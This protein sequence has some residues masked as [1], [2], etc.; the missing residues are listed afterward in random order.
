[1][2]TPPS[3]PRRYADV[4]ARRPSPSLIDQRAEV[5]PS[6]SS[7]TS[8]R[9][10]I[11]SPDR[12]N[13]VSVTLAAAEQRRL[14]PNINTL[15]LRSDRLGTLVRSLSRK[16]SSSR[17]WESFVTGHRGR[18][19]LSSGLEGID[20]PAIPL[21]RRW[22]DHGVPV[23]TSDLPWSTE[24][25]DLCIRRG[26]HQSAVQHNQF[27]RE[28]MAEFIENGFWTV[29][30]YRQVRSLPSLMLS[31]AAVKEERERK[32]R[33]LCDHSWNPVNEKTL[34]HAPPEAM[35]FGGTLQRILRRI[36]HADPKYGPVYLSK[37]DIKDGFY[38]LF[39]AANDCPRLSI[40]LP[41]YPEEE[42]LVAIPLACTM[43]WTQSPPSFCTMSETV[44]DL[45]NARLR[46]KPAL[47]V[48]S[49][50]LSSLA[51][52]HDDVASWARVREPQTAGSRHL[53]NT[54]YKLPITH[55]DVFVD[56]FILLGQGGPT[57][58]TWMRD[59][60]LHAVDDILDTPLPTEPRNEAV[61]VK[62]LRNGDGGWA[63][64]KLILGWILDSERKTI[65]LPPH[66]SEACTSLLQDLASSRR[67][68]TK[69][70]ASAMGKLR[71]ISYAVPGSAAL[72]SALQ[73][74]MNLG[75]ASNRIRITKEVRHSLLAFLTLLNDLSN[76]PTYL[77]EIIPEDPLFLGA[78]D[79]A[80]PGMGGVFFDG[81][82]SYLWRH[83]FPLAVQDRLVSTDRPHGT[84]TN[85][86]LEHAGLLAQLAVM[87]SVA[88][89]TYATVENLSDNTPA[90]SRV[91]KGALSKLGPASRLCDLASVHQ[92]AHRYCHVAS[93]I[94]GVSNVMADDASRLQHLTDSS[95][96]SHFAQT[97]PQ[98]TP[99][100]LLPLPSETA[101]ALTSALLCQSP[102]GPTPS[103]PPVLGTPPSASGPSSV[104]LSASTRAFETSPTPKPNCVTFSSSPSG[105]E[106]PA[107]PASLSE[108]IQ[109]RT[110]SWQWARG[111]PTWVNQ[112]HASRL[113]APTSIPYSLVS[114]S[115]SAPKTTQPPVP[116]QPASRS[117]AAST[118]SST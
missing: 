10:S 25:K 67:V 47:P 71:F 22:R 99:W 88:D 58:L 59:H 109:Y 89:L 113:T 44:T 78:T 98:P 29:L 100:R 34:P 118:P 81:T 65:E 92:R 102:I 116:T 94:P 103:K 14:R 117:S 112:I 50:R 3:L 64:R 106:R 36:R 93:F 104:S 45:I 115:A 66:R 17:S 53:S 75:A 16:L 56:D 86:D 33:I 5:L 28:E 60:L 41:L 54:A 101:S 97:Y 95:F 23:L 73:S 68:S 49:H 18:S 24:T 90:V 63:T 110:P 32:P 37:F 30:P 11:A 74:A 80:K 39:L 20:H 21:L 19:Y 96:L 76:R 87:A 62:K 13:S 72:F 42:Q 114:S 52:S 108:L 15:E 27:L 48:P 69:R 9:S 43:G 70:W 84:V 4:V 40:I 1:M 35:Q 55:A 57:R 51:A 83:A 77:A 26:C 7:T 91:A 79:A 85:S 82:T 31:P 111:F 107:A 6:L 105:T 61:S 8:P 46:T 2:A 12:G 38:R